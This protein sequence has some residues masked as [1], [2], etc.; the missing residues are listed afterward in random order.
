MHKVGHWQIANVGLRW[1]LE[2]EMRILGS[3]DWQCRHVFIF[4]TAK[5]DRCEKCGCSFPKERSQYSQESK[6][7]INGGAAKQCINSFSF[8]FIACLVC[9]LFVLFVYFCLFFI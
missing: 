6:W 1:D 9:W 4:V 8:I 2:K 3:E 7:E 5:R